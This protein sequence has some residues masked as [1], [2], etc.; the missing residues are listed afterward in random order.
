MFFD[1]HPGKK[2]FHSSSV[3]TTKG[4]E[5]TSIK[6]VYSKN[7]AGQ[8]YGDLNYVVLRDYFAVKHDYC[9]FKLGQVFEDDPISIETNFSGV[10]NQENLLIFGTGYVSPNDPG[11]LPRPRQFGKMTLDIYSNEG[12][13]AK[14]NPSATLAGDSGGGVYQIGND[15]EIKLIGVS[16][17][18]TRAAWQ[19][20]GV[21]F[22]GFNL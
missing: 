11:T 5:T 21:L 12:I 17:T 7:F 15:F 6:G 1:K 22:A 9:F 16:S 19:T 13:R 18:A 2:L 8:F 14:E 10:V 20:T 4:L 3:T